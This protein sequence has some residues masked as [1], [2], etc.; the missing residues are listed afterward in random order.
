M[1]A[2]QICWSYKVVINRKG[3]GRNRKGALWNLQFRPKAE[4]NRKATERAERNRKKVFRLKEGCF[5]RNE[6]F[7]PKYLNNFL[8]KEPHFGH[9]KI[10]QFRPK[11]SISAE[12]VL[13][14]KMLIFA[15]TFQHLPKPKLSAKSRNK[16]LSVDH[17]YKDTYTLGH[18]LGS[19]ILF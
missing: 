15:E 14:A 3:F 19:D 16:A 10:G 11:Q 5:G 6:V 8:P 9:A 17:Y 7:W 4:T 12:N 2:F 13:S 1:A 18:P